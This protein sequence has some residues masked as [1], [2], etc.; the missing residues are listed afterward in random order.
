MPFDFPWGSANLRWRYRRHKDTSGVVSDKLSDNPP[1]EAWDTFLDTFRTKYPD[2]NEHYSARLQFN[3][4]FA[5]SRQASNQWPRHVDAH[6][7]VR[8]LMNLRQHWIDDLSDDRF[9]GFQM[10]TWNQGVAPAS[11]SGAWDAWEQSGTYRWAEAI[12]N[13]T[14][15]GTEGLSDVFPTSSKINSVSEQTNNTDE[16]FRIEYQLAPTTVMGATGITMGTSTIMGKRVDW[17]IE[18]WTMTSGSRTTLVRT[19]DEG[20]DYPNGTNKSI[21]PH[22]VY[23]GNAVS[24]GS[25]KLI[26]TAAFWEGYWDHG[27]HDGENAPFVTGSG[28]DYGAF[29]VVDGTRL[30]STGEYVEFKKTA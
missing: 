18:I 16:G 8:T 4:V 15:A 24:Q 29:L 25:G 5:C 6:K 26:G 19:I 10:I 9:T 7:T 30:D 12:Q 17:H 14:T 20:Y 2:S 23:S 28:Q 11:G 1:W 22:G 13:E 21:S 3:P 27:T